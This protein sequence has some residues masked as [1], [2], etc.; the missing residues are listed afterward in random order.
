MSKIILIIWTISPTGH[1]DRLGMDGFMDMKH[2]WGVA[3]SLTAPN[4][5]DGWSPLQA[6]RCA[7]V[8]K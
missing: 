3:D 6:A 2:C 8:P 5:K 7:T 1:I 4:P